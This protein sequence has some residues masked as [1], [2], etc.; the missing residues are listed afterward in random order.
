M[1]DNNNYDIIVIGGGATGFGVA[2][3]AQTRGFRVL[4][5]EAHDFAQGASS[6]STKLV[7]GGIRYLANLD[8]AL[9]KEGLAERY[10][11]LQN[12]PH[13]AQRQ[14]YLIPFYSW[15]DKLKYI[16][17][18]KLY[19]FL[20]GSYSIGKSKLLRK[21]DMPRHVPHLISDKLIGGV[22]YLDGQF[23][24]TRLLISLFKTFKAYGGT[25]LNY[26]QVTQIIHDEHGVAK[27]VQIR[28]N[29]T[30]QTHS[31][32]AQVIIN[33]TGVLVDN[34]LKLDNQQTQH[35]HVM[36]AQGTHLVFQRSVFDS[37]HALV[38]PKTSDNRILFVLPWHDKI[39]V[40]TTDIPVTNPTVEPLPSDDEVNFILETLNQYTQT[41]VT[42]QDILAKF[43]GLRPLVKTSHNST[44]A[45]IS[46]KH[47]ILRTKSNV[48]T[49]VGGKWTIYRLM[50][51]DTINYILRH[52]LL[53]PR[54]PSVS[55]N[56]H[57]IDYSLEPLD[58][59]LS[60][61]G[62]EASKIVAI[63][64]EQNNFAKLHAALP[65]Y[66]AEI[67]YHVRYEMA[68]TVADVLA[69]RTRAL[70]LDAQ[71]SIEAAPKVAEL[72]AQ[73]LNLDAAWI[74]RQLTEYNTYATHYCERKE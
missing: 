9:V 73:E 28:D 70:L 71:A 64:H 68:R 16:V 37:A 66:Q 27:Q 1:H 5:V 22:V 43:A 29:L 31:Y 6:K 74:S 11:L 63:Q 65:Y 55:R 3:E 15:W 47:Q 19:D 46:R 50:G 48:I 51:E 33:A 14:T 61:Y 34:I 72:M 7:H 69:R 23:D 26:T 54:Q 62:S 10:F 18:V 45:K 58:Y 41:K 4:L 30:Q 59:P 49:I 44:T 17:G 20:S 8:F 42:H 36:A 67:I 35:T 32:S 38:I 53:A 60:V 39:I 25:A 56:L 21:K 2:L 13:L 40:G 52:G 12:A 57:L 24:D